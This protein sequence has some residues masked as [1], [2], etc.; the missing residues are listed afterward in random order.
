MALRRNY[1][2]RPPRLTAALTA[3]ALLAAACGSSDN[4]AAT[5]ENDL[6]GAAAEIFS[7][8]CAAPVETELTIYSGRDEELVGPVLDAF[9]CSSGISVVTNFGDPTDLALALVEEG[10]RT[11]ADVFLSKS[12]GSVGF[13]QGEGFL[14]PLSNDLLGLVSADNAAD[15]GTWVGI[16]GR[17][18]VLVYNSELVSEDDLPDSIFELT[19][20]EY[21]GQVAIPAT[22]GSFQDWFT[23]FRAQEGNDVAAQWLADMVANDAIV[24]ESN[25]PTVDAVGRG[26]F[27]FGLVNHYYNFQQAEALGDNHQALNH[28]FAADDI[29]SLVIVTAAGITSTTTSPDEA[30]Q[31]IEFMLSEAAQTYFTTDSLEYPLGSGVSPAEVLPALDDSGSDFDVTFDD[32]GNGLEETIAIIE[33]SGIF[34]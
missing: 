32:L 33:E 4:T 26:E 2:T 3:V 31:L 11:P 14:Q 12:P 10:D 24:T 30:Q 20:E 22:N 17:Q 5:T 23:V 9:A 34:R 6:E 19:G 15:N 28:N 25:R 29:G 7:G 21:R 8:D 27:N 13:L 16:T 1:N 18:R